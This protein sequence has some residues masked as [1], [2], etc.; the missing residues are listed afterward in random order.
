MRLENKVSLV[1]GAGQGIGRA[2]ALAFASEGSA[3]VVNDI[4]LDTAQ[5]TAQEII[6]MGGKALAIRA[7]VSRKDEVNSM[8]EQV[9][10][11][12][13]KIDILV[14]NAGIQTETPFLDLSEDDFREGGPGSQ[15]GDGKVSGYNQ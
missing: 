5:A 8:V 3:V 13:K 1:T 9:I 11:N 15:E 12:F 4:N 7:D 6:T 10:T 2:I 14:N